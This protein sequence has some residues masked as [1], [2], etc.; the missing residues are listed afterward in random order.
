MVTPIWFRDLSDASIGAL[1]AHP[2]AM[3]DPDRRSQTSF[4]ERLERDHPDEL[5]EGL[6]TLR[7]QLE[8]GL[9][10]RDE[11]RAARERLGDASVL[12]WQKA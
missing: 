12:W 6:A 3:L 9:D 10:P 1:C 11:R 5:S 7:A 8:T 2:A 4:F